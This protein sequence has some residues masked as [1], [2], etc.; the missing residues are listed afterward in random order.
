MILPM[1]W[2][3]FSIIL[4]ASGVLVLITIIDSNSA[5][6]SL[7]ISISCNDYLVIQTNITFSAA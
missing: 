6:N 1:A 3:T 2:C 4:L 5:K 7:P